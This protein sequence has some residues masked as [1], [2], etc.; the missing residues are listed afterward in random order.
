M[1][2]GLS[3]KLYPEVEVDHQLEDSILYKELLEKVRNKPLTNYIYAVYSQLGVAAQMDSRGFSK[4][5]QGQH[6][7]KDVYQFLNISNIKN[8]S[9][10]GTGNISRMIGAMDSSG[11]LVN[12]TNAKEALQIAAQANIAHPETVSYIVQNGEAFNVIT[13]I[14]DARTQLR[15]LEVKKAQEVW[16][17]MEQAFANKGIDINSFDFNRRLVNANNGKAFMEWLVNLQGTRNSLFS[18]KEVRTLLAMDENSSQVQ[19]LVR[20]FGSIDE[21]ASNIYEAFHTGRSNY[22]QSQHDLMNE[23][24]NVCKRLRGLDVNSLNQQVKSTASEIDVNSD[25]RKVQIMLD[26]LDSEYNINADEVVRKLGEPIKSLSDAAADAAAVLQSRLDTILRE[27]GVTQEAADLRSVI[28]TLLKEINNKRYFS[29]VMGFLSNTATQIQTMENLFAEANQIP[30]TNLEVSIA[31]S[32]AMMKIQDIMNGY[33]PIVEAL[34]NV[35]GLIVD[36][37]LDSAD[38]ANIQEKAREIRNIFDTYKRRKQDLATNTMLDIATNFLGEETST[39]MAVADI[40][41]MARADSTIWDHFYSVGRV[42]NTMVAILGNILRDA[43][44][45][46]TKKLSDISLRIRRANK[47]LRD[48]GSDSSFMYDPFDNYIISDLDW[49]EYKNARAAAKKAFKRE[50]I[51]G[52]ALM[53]AME[54]WERNNTE[55]R[56]VDYKSGR[57]ERVPGAEYRR[58]FPELTSA[59]QE[60]YNEMMQIKGEI[61]TL[62]PHYAQKQYLPPQMRR[63]FIDAIA[64]SKGNP[65]KIAIAIL[66][67]M[68]DL[69]TVREDDQMFA[70]NGIIVDGEEYGITSGSMSGTPY[71]QIPI[72][73]INRLKDQGELLKDFSG[74]LQALAATA[75]NYECMN[76]IR[77]TVEFMGDYIKGMAPA[78]DEGKLAS[79]TTFSRG[80]TVIKELMGF[81]KSAG[82][83]GLIDSFLNQHIYGVKMKDTG[84]WVK[85]ANSL[86]GLTSIKA[87]TVNVKGMVA[88]YLVGEL[89]MLIEAGAGEF[90]NLKDYAWANAMVFGDNTLGVA[91]RINDFM[92]N[93]TNSMSVLLAQRFDPRVDTYSEL[94]RERYFGSKFRHLLS[95][96]LKFIGYGMGEHMIHYVTMYAILNHEKVRIDGVEHSLYDAFYKSDKED[97]SSELLVKDNVTYKNEEGNWV[98]VDEAYLDKIKKRIRGCNQNTHGSMNEEDKGIIHQRMVG[99]YIMNLRQW[100]VEHYSRR[101]RAPHWD[102]TLGEFREGFYYTV[103]NLGLSW[104]KAISRFNLEY[105]TRWD[106]LTTAQK[107]N[108][109]RAISELIVFASLLTLSFAI[110]EPDDH[111]R[112]FWMRFFIYQTKRAL[113]EVRGSAPYGLSLEWAKLINNPVPATNTINSFLYLFFGLPDIMETINRGRYKGWNKYLGNVTKYWVPFY[114][115]IQQLRE[116]DEDESLFKVFDKGLY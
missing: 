58:A 84:K 18:L 48:S 6:K 59:Q 108:V 99:R 39:G 97:G 73:Y 44:D 52:L 53:E 5:R 86:L 63:S 30:G 28:N 4:N 60:Y 20:M 21:A 1:S 34:S 85:L 37:S 41:S 110:G 47:K 103:G 2:R 8:I 111:K 11:N 104:I 26:S 43:Q 71:R 78:P 70:K 61:G 94:S 19:R 82:T 115:Q 116:M 112:E 107:Y 22:S 3:C 45:Q 32:K 64:A 89:Q 79:V 16:G 13:Q 17:I 29:G 69:V 55:E 109:N 12:F 75:I 14:K 95:T 50:G 51:H 87:L 113:L 42:S 57:T 100:M 81:A 38:R 80:A 65:K 56:I 92:T 96:D 10:G 74:A 9:L 31:K 68:K 49:A 76:N 88:N 35:E 77:D 102:A 23:A 105:A 7:A 62:L 90:Y 40:V 25:E 54:Q 83:A 27:E 93:S 91:G 106:E 67:K 66:N 46:R 15:S 24:L 36:E 98:P 114:D 33:Y 72:F 101:Y